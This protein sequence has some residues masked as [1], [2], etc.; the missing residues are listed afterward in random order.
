[1][2][3]RERVSMEN[4]NEYHALRIRMDFFKCIGRWCELI[5]HVLDSKETIL[6]KH[7]RKPLGAVLKLRNALFFYSNKD[8]NRIALKRRGI[9]RCKQ[10]KNA[11]SNLSTVPYQMVIFFT[12]TYK[13]LIFCTF[14]RHRK[15]LIPHC[16]GR[17]RAEFQKSA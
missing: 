4:R 1:M 17:R 14:C 5:C 9:Q 7:I 8:E 16:A 2:R 15:W 11:Q 12:H 3:Q 10:K 6:L 13:I